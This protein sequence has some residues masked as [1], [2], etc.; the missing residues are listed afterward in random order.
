MG[1]GP[2]LL[3]PRSRLANVRRSAAGRALR[4]RGPR[5]PPPPAR[6]SVPAAGPRGQVSPARRPRPRRR[7]GRSAFRA[8]REA[9][10]PPRASVPAPPPRTA[11]PRAGGKRCSPP[12]A[13]SSQ[14][15]DLDDLPGGALGGELL[16]EKVVARARPRGWR[17]P[18]GAR[19][20]GSWGALAGGVNW[21][22]R[23]RCASVPRPV[24]WGCRRRQRFGGQNDVGAAWHPGGA[25]GRCCWALG[26]GPPL[27]PPDSS[28]RGHA[29]RFP[30]SGIENW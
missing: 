1:A 12:E 22:A 11:A 16:A 20:W 4:P 6:P 30:G 9:G 27:A 28:P 19:W 8:E 3:V 5:A 13:V 24:K 21:S 10:P 23:S 17:G 14:R 29:E 26:P 7:A 18:R 15:L 25:A 2:A